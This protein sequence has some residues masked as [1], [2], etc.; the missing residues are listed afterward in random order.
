MRQL[1]E[2]GYETVQNR[3]VTVRTDQN[4]L[5]LYFIVLASRHSRGQD[6]WRKIT[7][8]QPSGQRLLDL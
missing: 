1:R 8:I 3:E 6:F 4:N 7:Q 2:L 5:L